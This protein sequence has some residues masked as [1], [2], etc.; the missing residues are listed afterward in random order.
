MIAIATSLCFAAYGGFIAYRRKGSR[1]DIAQYAGGFA[2]LG[3]I[4]GV[5]LT[6]GFGRAV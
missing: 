4:I 2:L 6:I 5:A 1:A 3:L